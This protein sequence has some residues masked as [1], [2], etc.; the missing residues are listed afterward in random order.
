M[1]ALVQRPLFY[2][3]KMFSNFWFGTLFYFFQIFPKFTFFKCFQTFVFR[4]TVL[5]KD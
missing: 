5:V 3:L 2:F 4:F 1:V